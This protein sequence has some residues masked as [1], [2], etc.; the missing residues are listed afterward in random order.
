MSDI[1]NSVEPIQNGLVRAF[2]T[3]SAISNISN[4]VVKNLFR[5]DLFVPFTHTVPCIN[6]SVQCHVKYQQVSSCKHQFRMDLFVPFT[7]YHAPS[8][9]STVWKICSTVCW[10]TRAAWAA[11]RV[12]SQGSWWR[13]TRDTTWTPMTLRDITP[14]AASPSPTTSMCQISFVSTK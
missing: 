4:S 1:S 2:H 11:R 14:T 6:N 9:Q 3:Y 12:V 8:Q 13:P 10:R 7:Q 5:I